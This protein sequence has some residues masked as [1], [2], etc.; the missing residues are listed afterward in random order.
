MGRVV[1]MVDGWRVLMGLGD[2]DG[3][4]MLMGVRG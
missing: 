2:I 3:D 4:G 1:R